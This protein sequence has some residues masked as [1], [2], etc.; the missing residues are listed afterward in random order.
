MNY[1]EALKTLINKKNGILLTKDVIELGIPR[2]YIYI[3]VEENLLEKVAHGVYMTAEALSDEMYIIQSMSG[4]AIFSHET[5]L[6]LHELTDRDPL[7]YTVTVPSGYNASSLKKRGVN[8]YFI[9]KELHDLGIVTSHTIMNREILIY[10]MERTIC[11]I[12][13]SRNKIDIAIVNEALKRYIGRS[14]KN[15]PKLMRYAKQMKIDSIIRNYLEV[16]Q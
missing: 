4:K 11:D 6:Y 15:I 3:L 7:Q 2:Q 12:V 8:V 1:K 16:L 14:D 9:K 13:R 10:D 5:S